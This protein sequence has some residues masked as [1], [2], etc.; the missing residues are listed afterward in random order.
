MNDI[1]VDVTA[2]MSSHQYRDALFTAYEGKTKEE[3]KEI[4]EKYAPIGSEIRKREL[5]LVEQGAMM[6]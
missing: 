5:S 4:H 1:K 2:E 3:C 6:G